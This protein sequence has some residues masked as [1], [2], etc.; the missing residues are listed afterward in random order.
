[1][2]AAGT[3]ARMPSRRLCGHGAD[4]PVPL[5][6]YSVILSCGRHAYLMWQAFDQH[7]PDFA[8]APMGLFL[9]TPY[10]HRFHLYRQLVPI[11]DRAAGTIAKSLHAMIFIAAPE[12]GKARTSNP[13]NKAKNP[14]IAEAVTTETRQ[15]RYYTVSTRMKRVMK[16]V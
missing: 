14:Y 3:T 16:C 6:R 13:D 5:F 4:S 15:T 7:L 2:K 8:D 11:P 12:Q 10:N 1:M 9:A